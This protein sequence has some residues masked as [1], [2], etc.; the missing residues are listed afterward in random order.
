VFFLTSWG[1]FQRRFNNILEDLARHGEQIDK[2]ANAYNIAEAKNMRQSLEAWRQDSLAKLVRDEEEQTANELR[3]ICTWLKKNETDQLI[4][5]DKISSE[6]SNHPGTCSWVLQHP[7]ISSWLRNQSDMTFL[8]L[9]GNPGTGKSVIAGQLVH[10]LNSSQRSLVVSHFCT[11]SYTSSTQYDQILKSL[12]F[13]LVR[14]NCDLVAHIYGRYIVEKRSASVPVLEQLLQTVITA[15]S[16]DLDRSQSIHMIIDGL[17]EIDA[18]K[19]GRLINLMQRVLKAQKFRGAACK[20]LVS[21]RTSQLLKR[22]LGKKPTVSLSDEKDSLEHAIRTYAEQKLK[23]QRYR[24]SEL[25]LQDYDLE[26]IGQ[27]IARKA[28]GTYPL[29]PKKT[30]SRC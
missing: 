2:E 30:L 5:F 10:F 11:Y 15:L 14:A 29:T 9:Q 25:G 24:L 16:G 20:V 23:A 17:D 3:V 18:E 21:C 7:K 28:D 27:S 13:Q 12:L 22:A 6:G 1:R 8:W 26:D 19:Q 4:I